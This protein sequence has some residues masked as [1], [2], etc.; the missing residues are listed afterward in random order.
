MLDVAPQLQ[1]KR[2]PAALHHKRVP[3]QRHKVIKRTYRA[4]RWY[5]EQAHGPIPDGL[6]LDHLCSQRACVNPDHMESVSLSENIRRGSNAKL[7]HDKADEI[8][9]QVVSGEQQ[10]I[11]AERFAISEAVVSKIVRGQAWTR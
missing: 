10:R 6:T 7:T 3:G 11:V 2:L 8:R 5:Y 9:R 4:H 1:P